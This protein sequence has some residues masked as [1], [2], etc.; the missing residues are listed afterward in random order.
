MLALAKGKGQRPNQLPGSQFPGRPQIGK[1]QGVGNPFGN[2]LGVYTIES[3][4]IFPNARCVESANDAAAYFVSGE[5]AKG[6][7]RRRQESWV[8]TN[9]SLPQR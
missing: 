7:G 4:Q 8:L 6:R 1:E 5:W 9:V 2:H 3:W